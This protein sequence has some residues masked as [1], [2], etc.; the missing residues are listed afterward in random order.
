MRSRTVREG[1]VGLLILLGIAVFGGIV[2]WLRGFMPGSRSY[3]FVANFPDTVGMQAG[4]PV[5]YRGV[6]VGR[7]TDITAGSNGVAVTIEIL[8]A[9]LAIP[10]NPT[11]EANQSGLI[12]ETSIDIRPPKLRNERGEQI[13]IVLPIDLA[14]KPL[15]ANCQSAN[16]II[17]NNDVTVGQKGVNL[18]DLLTATTKLSEAYSSPEFKA[19]LN[20]ATRNGAEAAKELANLS[21]EFTLLGRSLRQELRTFSNTAVS[22]S[23]SASSTSEEVRLMADRIANTADKFGDTAD[24]INQTIGDFGGTTT[25]INQTFG[26]FGT[27]ADRLNQTIDRFGGRTDEIVATINKFGQT[28]DKFNLLATN[29]NSLVGDNK[30]TLTA[31]LSNF[32]EASKQ[33]SDTLSTLKPMLAKIDASLSEVDP[34]EIVRN[35]ETV[36]ANAA[37]ISNNLKD[38]SANLNDPKNLVTLQQ[39]LDSARATFENTQKITADLDDLTG[40]PAF[41]DNL[42]NLVNGL[43]KLVSS[44]EQLQEQVQTAQA[45]EPIT[46]ASDR[47]TLTFPLDATFTPS[48]N[49]ESTE[50]RF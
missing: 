24:R 38:L 49:L 48:T 40:D 46:S 29:L 21:R 32:S 16:S 27:T 13:E 5:R 10:R 23:D 42:K 25:Q 50:F 7:I 2:L 33:L 31:T 37:Q 17:C 12:G 36:T 9:D 44:T 1:S 26:K 43:G 47:Q 19:N 28:A 35:L 4:A 14:T 8:K 18:Y 15:D 45:L 30:A 22:L 6:Q 11:I 3:K 41:R 20:A 39:T 34:A